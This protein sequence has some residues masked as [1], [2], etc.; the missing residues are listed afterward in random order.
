MNIGTDHAK[1]KESNLAIS[2]FKKAIAL[3]PLNYYAYTNLG[4]AYHDKGIEKQA[5]PNYEK[6][7]RTD[8]QRI[9]A[10][11]LLGTLYADK[12]SLDQAIENY[13]KAQKINPRDPFLL[14][15]TG[16]IL[17]KQG[18]NDQA[19]KNLEK[20][21][22]LEPNI[23]F[24][25]DSLGLAYSE[26]GLSEK[27]IDQYKKALELAT[28]SDPN[29]W[30][31]HFDLAREYS[32]KELYDESI[33]QWKQT[34]KLGPKYASFHNSLAEAFFKLGFQDKALAEYEQATK[35]DPTNEIALHNIKQITN[36][37]TQLKKKPVKNN[38]IQIRV[39]SKA[40]RIINNFENEL[41]LFIR[42]KLEEKYG[43]K[44]WM[45]Q[46]PNAIQIK[47]ADRKKEEI[48]D[49]R[50]WGREIYDLH[51]IFYSDFM[52]LREIIEKADNYRDVFSRFFTSKTFLQSRFEE[53]HAIIRKPIAH[54]R[55]T[56]SSEDLRLL[57]YYSEDIL[58]RI[59]E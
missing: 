21:I 2:Y 3:D 57:K 58:R 1:R 53:I 55:N 33:E 22:D 39:A 35:I 51:P 37:Q 16:N 11:E 30:Q 10:Y 28:D 45:Q 9:D 19:I 56:I 42:K 12:G 5:I 15:N 20:A 43:E 27:A 59:R 6:A 17:L 23:A 48:E 7:I 4:H 54:N 36:A 8:P 31:Y 34:I 49:R 41:R 40:Y 29:K 38:T 44:W 18:F 24:F 14:H 25:H 50:K 32:D 46:I 26:K 13:E 47:C 52:M